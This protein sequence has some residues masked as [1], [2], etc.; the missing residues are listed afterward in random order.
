M[1]RINLP[2]IWIIKL[3]NS[4]LDYLTMM[5]V[6]PVLL[7]TWGYTPSKWIFGL[8]VRGRD[9]G[10]ISWGDAMNRTWLVFAKIGR[11]HV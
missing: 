8:Q 3:M 1:L 11:A 5:V 10:K 7:S 4:Y 9:G 2:D 6:E